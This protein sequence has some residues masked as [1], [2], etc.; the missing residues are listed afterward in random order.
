MVG[1]NT[2]SFITLPTATN[3]AYFEIAAQNEQRKVAYQNGTISLPDRELPLHKRC[4]YL[5]FEWFT[6]ST[7]CP[8]LDCISG[9]WVGGTT[10][11]EQGAGG[12][13]RDR[14]RKATN[15]VPGNGAGKKQADRGPS[16]KW[17]WTGGLDTQTSTNV[18]GGG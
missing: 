14:L 3:Q 18:Q 10:A 12:R 4:T 9:V 13:G 7:F 1:S 16:Y 5:V 8:C 11:T 15:K 6:A 17:F 2:T